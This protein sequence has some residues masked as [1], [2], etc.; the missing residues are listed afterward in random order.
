MKSELNIA[1]ENIKGCGTETKIYSKYKWYSKKWEIFICGKTNSF[2]CNDCKCNVES[3]KTTCQRWLEFLEG[4]D[5]RIL[6]RIKI[7]SGFLT[8]EII[9]D[10]PKVE[11]LLL[12]KKITDLKQAIKLYEDAEI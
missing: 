2:L 12:T 11:P 1:E 3:H 9:T 4:L 10:L 6:K 7:L 5:D 8:D